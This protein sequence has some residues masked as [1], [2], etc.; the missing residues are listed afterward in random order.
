[1][2]L[3]FG[4]TFWTMISQTLPVTISL[5]VPLSFY[6]VADNIQVNAPETIVIT[7][8]GKRAPLNHLDYGAIAFHVD[9]TTLQEGKN[10]ILLKAEQLFLPESI[11]LLDYNPSPL[12]I[13]MHQKPIQ[14]QEPQKI[15]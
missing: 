9:G 13:D 11:N 4:Y 3:F 6:N 15:S 14:V 1:M 12:V 7:L 5:S 10:Y 8:R 2:S